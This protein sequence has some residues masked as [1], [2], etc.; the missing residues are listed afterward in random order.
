LDERLQLV[1]EQLDRCV[2]P[3]SR[4]KR[5]EFGECSPFD[6]SLKA[7]LQCELGAVPDL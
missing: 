7:I 3:L 5:L 1:T 4:I 2:N 6:R